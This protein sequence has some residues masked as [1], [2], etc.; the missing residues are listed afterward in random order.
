MA[1]EFKKETLEEFNEIVKRYPDKQAATIPALHLMQRDQGYV[2]NEALEYIAGLLD[3]PV[4]TVH[5]TVSYYTMFY[6]EEMGKYVIQV[7]STLSCYILGSK[8]IVDHIENK[9]GI[10]AGETTE[11]RKFSLIKVECLGA[12]GTAPVIRIN[13]DYYEDLTIE[14]VDEIL[15]GLQ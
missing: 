1:I 7:C 13:D 4:S 11:D 5:S 9:L 15:N 8:N 14:K 3:L 6:R 2:S 12:C 10:K